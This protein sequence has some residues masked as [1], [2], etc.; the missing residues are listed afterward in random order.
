MDH[1]G[2]ARLDQ[3]NRPPA[4]RHVAPEKIERGAAA[5]AAVH[6]GPFVGCVATPGRAADRLGP[7][8]VV[9]RLG[10]VRSRRNAK[11]KLAPPPFVSCWDWPY[12]IATFNYKDL[13]TRR[14]LSPITM[15]EVTISYVV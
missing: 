9:C 12:S 10:L 13:A 15:G 11:R 4:R 8:A 14:E 1:T 7:V 3:I 6:G 2:D 5:A